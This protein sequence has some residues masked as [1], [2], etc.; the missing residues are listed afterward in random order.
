MNTEVK[1]GKYVLAVSGGVDS[2]V[3]LDILSKQKDVQLIV[4]HYDHG[5]RKESGQDREF[6]QFTAD[7]LSLPFESESGNLGERTSEAVAREK[8]YD[9]LRKMKNKYAANSI[10][11]AHHQDDLLETM[12]LNIW[13]GTHRKGLSSL[14]SNK[15]LLRPLLAYTKEQLITYAKQQ[16]IDWVEDKTNTDTR[17]VRNYIRAKVMPHIKQSQ[18][19]KLLDIQKKIAALNAQIDQEIASLLQ[20]FNDTVDRSWFVQLPFAVACEVVAEI[21]RRHEQELTQMSI[22]NT[23]IAVRTLPLG[24]RFEISGSLV[25][26]SNKQQVHFVRTST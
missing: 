10:I 23:V 21:L 19:K 5:I 18:R 22:Y 3:L 1:P 2:M 13:R 25:I 8:R 14:S 6:V 12:V 17:Y 16:G 9:F 15:D 26:E 24:K 7:R 4:A 20:D 11:T